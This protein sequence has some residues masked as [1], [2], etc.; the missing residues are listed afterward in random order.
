LYQ[1]YNSNLSSRIVFLDTSKAFD[2]IDHTCMLFKVQQLGIVG[3]L[4]NL[5]TSSN[6]VSLSAFS[7]RSHQQ[8]PLRPQIH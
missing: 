4:L 6:L 7:S 8:A 5:L 3:P 2:R 1:A